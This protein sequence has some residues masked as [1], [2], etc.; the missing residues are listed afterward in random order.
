[1]SPCVSGVDLTDMSGNL[2]DQ[3][4]EG[5]VQP[6]ITCTVDLEHS[7]LGGGDDGVWNVPSSPRVQQLPRGEEALGNG[8]I[9]TDHSTQK[10][11]LNGCPFCVHSLVWDVL[12]IQVALPKVP[13]P[14]DFAFKANACG[15]C[16]Q[17][18]LR[19]KRQRGPDLR[20]C[21][22]VQRTGAVGARPGQT[23]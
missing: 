21:G 9:L 11:Q 15:G 8:L 18:C 16:G 17:G 3:L 22:R 6:G 7:R 1:M 10:G 23:K 4:F 14:R 19:P 5:V 12:S 20:A 13:V 2:I